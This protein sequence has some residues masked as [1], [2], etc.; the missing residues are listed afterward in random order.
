MSSRPHFCLIICAHCSSS[1]GKYKRFLNASSP[2]AHFYSTPLTAPHPR[3]APKCPSSYEFK[4][5]WKILSNSEFLRS[6][7]EYIISGMQQSVPVKSVFISRRQQIKWK[8]RL[9]KYSW[10]NESFQMEASYQKVAQFSSTILSP[11]SFQT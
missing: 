2:N 11:H 5:C 3:P 4:S 8:D 1:L 10:E 7:S 9:E 6:V